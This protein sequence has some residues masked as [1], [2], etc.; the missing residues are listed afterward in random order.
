MSLLTDFKFINLTSLTTVENKIMQFFGWLLF[1]VLTSVTLL[2]CL[3]IFN[4]KHRFS[5]LAC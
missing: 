5:A 2:F 3:D 1:I 4:F